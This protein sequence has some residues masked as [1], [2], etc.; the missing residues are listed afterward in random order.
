MNITQ[1]ECVCVYIT[2]GIQPAMRVCHIVICG[3]PRS[4]I[5]STLSHKRHYFRKEV[6]ENQMCAL[7]FS[8]TFVGNISHSKKK[9]ARYDKNVYWPAFKIPHVISNFNE[10]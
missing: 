5:F 1:P 10:T 9:W 3:L 8:T 7:I 4:A 6:T 2:L